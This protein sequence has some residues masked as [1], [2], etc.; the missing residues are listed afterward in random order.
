MYSNQGVVLPNCFTN[1][2]LLRNGEKKVKTWSIAHLTVNFMWQLDWATRCSDIWSDIIS[3]CVCKDVSGK[4]SH[5]NWWTEEGIW[6]LPSVG[7][8]IQSAEGLNR[9]KRWRKVV[10]ALP[11]PNCLSWTS[12]FCSQCPWFSG[13][14]TQT[15]NLHHWLSSSQDFRLQHQP[16]WVS[17]LHSPD[18]G[19]Y[20]VP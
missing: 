15:W 7:G 3:G 11:L 1:F 13:F 10:F 20:Q 19:T 2:T 5:F 4:D 18:H 9:T 17:S 16:S 6:P 12:I 8:I 14:Q